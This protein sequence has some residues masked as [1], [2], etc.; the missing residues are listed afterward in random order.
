MH[1]PLYVHVAA[2]VP[3]ICG[4]PAPSNR[5]KDSLWNQEQTRREQLESWSF[6]GSL[7]GYAAK[8]P[9]NGAA[10][11]R[12][13]WPWIN[14]DCWW[15]MRGL[16]YM[17]IYGWV[18]LSYIYV[19][20][21]N[22]TILYKLRPSYLNCYASLARPLNCLIL[23]SRWG[24]PGEGFQDPPWGKRERRAPA[25]PRWKTAVGRWPAM[26][27]SYT[28]IHTQYVI[29]VYCIQHARA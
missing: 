6:T 1:M 4:H 25:P 15:P 11:M 3:A 28:P 16:S 18:W 12:A 19:I 2:M 9:A 8:I 20:R 22:Q 5:P 17:V 23:G 14:S 21:H 10:Q 24:N 26:F 13:R 7:R 29:R 27:A